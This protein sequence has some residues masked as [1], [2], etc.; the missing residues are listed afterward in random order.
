[1]SSPASDV[2]SISRI[3]AIP[4]ILQVVTRITGMRFAAVAR[5]TETTWTCCAAYDLIDFGLKPGDEL[6]LETTICNEI[7]EHHQPVVFGHA[8]DHPTFSSHPTPKMYGFESY[9]SIPIM[10]SNGEFFGTLCA[11][12]PHA[13]DLDAPEIVESMELFAQLIA[14][15]LDTEERL[16]S[17]RTALIAAHERAKLREHFIAVLG[18]DL[19]NPL[20]SISIA[21]EVLESDLNDP[22]DLRKVGLIRGSCKR[23]LGLISDVLDFARG[24]L[25]G[26]ID[27]SMD[28]ADDLADELRQ[29][30]YEVDTAHPG[31]A[32]NMS[33]ELTELVVCDRRR[34]GQ[35]FS[36]LLINA[37]THGNPDTPV[38]VSIRSDK[39]HFELSV[40]NSG[41]AIPKDIAKKLFEPF[42]RGERESSSK[43]SL[44]LGLYIAAEIAKAHDG[45]I[46]VSSN[47]S[48]GT[49][50]VFTMPNKASKKR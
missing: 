27:L 8:S 5:V 22:R 23:M 33:M 16:I 12:D 39:H 32:V 38:D 14:L 31:H 50:F 1:M 15:N 7:R 19:R 30:A 24:A 9:I 17:S 35:L 29:V 37:I 48:E 43:K 3:R 25:G 34:I 20:A 49:R 42:S 10:L 13:A 2:Q 4:M 46:T 41:P 11:L 47:Q 18:H 21:A 44:G 45:K 40:A 36:N 26:G 28:E 6:K